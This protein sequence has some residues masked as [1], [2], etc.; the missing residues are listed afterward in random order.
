MMQEHLSVMTFLWSV[1]IV[2][3]SG[4][5]AWLAA[6]LGAKYA[7]KNHDAVLLEHAKRITRLEGKS[8]T[9]M[10]EPK[11]RLMTQDC[12]AAR[13]LET[14]EVQSRLDAIM[15][16]FSELEERRNK[17]WLEFEERTNHRWIEYDIR[18]EA[19]KDAVQK[20]LNSLCR[21]ITALE[22]T[23]EK[24]SKSFRITNGGHTDD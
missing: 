7:I 17:R 14:D 10:T 11:C 22:T 24:R 6:I 3:V 13:I 16:R 18:R 8:E 21:Q 4:I 23:I 2:V 9:A 19:Q 5:A 20:T 12:L 15:D 1:F